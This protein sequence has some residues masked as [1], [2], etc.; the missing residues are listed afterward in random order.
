MTEVCKKPRVFIKKGGL[1][2]GS[3]S[4]SVSGKRKVG[5]L[6]ERKRGAG[7]RMSVEIYTSGTDSF[8]TKILSRSTGGY[9]MERV[10]RDETF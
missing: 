5:S 7:R 6:E 8:R 3:T 4:Q 1:V 9:T 2:W 10:T